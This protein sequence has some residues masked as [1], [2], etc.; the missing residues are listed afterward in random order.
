[1]WILNT[2]YTVGL[3]IWK[4]HHYYFLNPSVWPLAIACSLYCL[5]LSFI[6]YFNFF[7][8]HQILIYS[9]ILLFFV[10]KLHYNI[11]GTASPYILSKLW[12]YFK[13]DLKFLKQKIFFFVFF[14]VL[15]NNEN[16]AYT[17]AK[18]QGNSNE[19]GLY[20]I[21]FITIGLWFVFH[22]DIMEYFDPESKEVR[23]LHEKEQKLRTDQLEEAKRS[24]KVDNEG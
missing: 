19:L 20:L 18:G 5:F 7:E 22:R 9:A 1:M 16:I 11:N 24:L 4:K 3:N 12:F 2:I 17:A 14:F 6:T 15:L 13:Q 23:L 10:I 8:M 21:G